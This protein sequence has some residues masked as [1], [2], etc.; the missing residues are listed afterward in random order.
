MSGARTIIAVVV[1]SL[2]L[3]GCG[4]KETIEQY[5]KSPIGCEVR[6]AEWYADKVKTKLGQDEL[7]K[8]IRSYKMRAEYHGR[9]TDFASL[10]AAEKSEQVNKTLHCLRE[11]MWAS[12]TLQKAGLP[13]E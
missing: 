8:Q 10:T 1:G 3:T 11:I 7:R 12:E 4:E 2:F 9:Q 13:V 5:A 6:P